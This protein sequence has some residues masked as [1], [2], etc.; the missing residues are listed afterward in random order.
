MGLWVL[1]SSSLRCLLPTSGIATF[2]NVLGANANCNARF[3]A[4][5]VMEREQK[6]TELMRI[7]GLRNGVDK[8]AYFT[9][10]M[11][12]TTVPT[13]IFGAILIGTVYHYSS[14]GTILFLIF[15]EL[16]SIFSLCS[17]VRYVVPPQM[18][19]DSLSSSI[20]YSFTKLSLLEFWDLSL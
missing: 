8:F 2:A 19:I 9:T 4:D 7:M 20:A 6:L 3:M 15:S 17:L 13:L 1:S 10:M 16:F 11:L 14:G 12:I 5:Y 18:V